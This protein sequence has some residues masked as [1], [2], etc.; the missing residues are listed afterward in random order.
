MSGYPCCEVGVVCIVQAATM[1]CVGLFGHEGLIR[2]ESRASPLR[3]TSSESEMS[4]IYVEGRLFD[5]G[6]SGLPE[7]VV[8]IAS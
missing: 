8:A 7:V 4:A 3:S 2:R 6:R 1:P 5:I